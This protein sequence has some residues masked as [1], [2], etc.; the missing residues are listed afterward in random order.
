[1][2]G[3]DYINNM[4]KI[5]EK[6]LK[7]GL[8]SVIGDRV[9]YR[10][11]SCTGNELEVRDTVIE[12][13]S[14]RVLYVDNVRESAIYR[15]VDPGSEFISLYQDLIADMMDCAPGIG[16]TLLIGGAGFIFPHYYI[17][18][19]PS[20]RMD[21]VEIDREM[22]RLAKKFF[23]LDELFEEQELAVSRR[24]E[25]FNCDGN[26]YVSGTRR[27]Y[28]AVINDAYDGGNPDPGLASYDGTAQ[29]HRI[30]NPGG[31]YIINL[32]TSIT[33]K[34]SMRLTM[35]LKILENHFNYVRYVRCEND[36]DPLDI[37]NVVIIASDAPLDWL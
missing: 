14:A 33:G 4:P 5:I 7:A 37:Q 2:S 32:I 6:K 12:G 29:I 16:N 8:H 10:G 19:Y 1:M 9:L 20:R 26:K 23:Y 30:L 3:S 21:V 22:I 15:D 35:S 18:R 17:R 28:D 31:I 24:L 11:R 27:R 25:I 13:R 36:R 34:Y